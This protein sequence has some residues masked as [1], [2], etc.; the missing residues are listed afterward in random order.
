MPLKHACM[1]TKVL[2]LACVQSRP[3]TMLAAVMHRVGAGSAGLCS[4]CHSCCKRRAAVVQAWSC[5]ASLGKPTKGVSHHKDAG[6]L[7][8]REECRGQLERCRETLQATIVK[9]HES[10]AA[11]RVLLSQQHCVL[12][13]QHSSSRLLHALGGSAASRSTFYT[14]QALC[15]AHMHAAAVHNNRGNRVGRI[16]HA[17]HHAKPAL[18]SRF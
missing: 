17:P 2:A 14:H 16:Q 8:G 15:V 1:Q 18:L 3:R 9:D 12:I 10:F 13:R 6:G 7:D 5:Q 11:H 4:A